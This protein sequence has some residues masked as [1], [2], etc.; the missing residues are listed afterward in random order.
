MPERLGGRSV[1][2]PSSSATGTA[3]EGSRGGRQRSQ[4]GREHLRSTRVP[5]MTG[6]GGR[7]DQLQDFDPLEGPLCVRDVGVVLV[8]LIPAI[9]GGPLGSRSIDSTLQ[10]AAMTLPP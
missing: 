5:A 8:E 2:A 4:G 10:G 3:A 7:N 6:D 1:T 9:P